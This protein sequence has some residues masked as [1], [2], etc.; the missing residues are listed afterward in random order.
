MHEVSIIESV[1]ETVFS[2]PEVELS[3]RITGVTLRIGSLSSVVEDSLRFAF[4]SLI[5][6]TKAEGAELTVEHVPTECQCRNCSLI[7]TPESP[8]YVCPNCEC[9]DVTI[10]HGRE[11]Q[12]ISV[13]VDDS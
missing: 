4:D 3:Q 10:I 7:Y 1:L 11:I 8:G 6:G 9:Q 5:I 2:N 13:E 12:V